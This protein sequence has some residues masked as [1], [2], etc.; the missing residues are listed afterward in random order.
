M[1]TPLSKTTKLQSQEKE[2]EFIT[3]LIVRVSEELIKLLQF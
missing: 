2:T 3:G 1:W